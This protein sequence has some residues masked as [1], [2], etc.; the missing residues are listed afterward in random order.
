MNL[1]YN[2]SAGTGKTYQVTGL[3]EKLVL[4]EGIDPREI[5][6]MTFTDNAAA[7]LRMRVSHR[8]MKA[9]RDGEA[10]G[11]FELAE[12][13]TSA[14][15]RLPSAPIGTIHSFCTR[16]LREHALEAGL[17][18]GFSVLI[19]DERDELLNRICR[20]E[21]LKQLDSDPD[22][23]TFCG[24]TQVIG[25]GKGFGSSVT[26]T[27]PDLI[28]QAGSLGISLE[29]AAG[30]LPEPKPAATIQDFSAIL[31]RLREL[32]KRTA[33]AQRVLDALEALLPECGNI[34]AL[35]ERLNAAGLKKF[36]R[37][38]GQKPISDDFSERL[39]AADVAIKYKQRY[40]A[41]LAF[42]RYIQT[43]ATR[44][45]QRKHEMDAVDF[46]D[47][48]HM[49]A[50]LLQTGKAKP[51]FKYVIVDEVQDTSRIQCDLIKAL[52]S[53]DTNLVIC[54]DKKQ[55]IYTWRGADP[56]V[57]PDLEAAIL[58]TE[59]GVCENLQTS[60]RSKA[61]ILDVVN[62]LF[63]AV[64][65]N[66]DYADGDRLL[67]NPDFETEGEKACVEF[68]E[69]DGCAELSKR[70]KVE[71]EMAA[72]ANRIHL[73]VNG[74]PDWKPAYRHSDGFEPT[75]N[76][77]EYR[78]SDILIL[79]RRTTHQ[80]VLEQ[81]LRHAGVPYTLGGKGRGLFT[82]QETR[83]VSLFLNV[84]TNPMDAYSLIGF[85]RS[86][87]VGLSDETL[88][89]LAWNGDDFSI[90]HLMAQ[91]APESTAGTQRLT[92]V[93]RSVPAA[94]AVVRRYRER[95]GDK[96]A[97][98]LVRMLIE[99]TGYDAL[100]AGLPRGT[101]R[102]ANLRKVL[103]WL[104]E[105]ERG[106]QT[107]PAAVARKLAQQIA[108]PPPVPEA[109]LLDPAQNAVTLMTVHGSKGLTKR[110]VMVPDI[111]SSPNADRG[112][113]RVFF[114]ADHHPR[115]GV[116]V[117]A[118]DKNQA[119]SPGFAEANERAKE[120]RAHEL[121]N[122]FYVAMTR[123]RDLVVVSATKGKTAAGW[124]KQLEP[125]IGTR[126]PAIP[127][128]ALADAVERPEQAPAPIPTAEQLAV[129]LESLAPAPA[130]PTLKRIPATR[131]AKEMDELEPDETQ[132]P[133]SF[134]SMDN[135]AALGSLGHAV[136]EQ[137]A[138]NHWTG[139]VDDW[140]EILRDGFGASKTEAA[141]MAP[142]IEQTRAL[143]TGLT[144]LVK[145]L[146]PEFPFVLLEG[147]TLID[148]TIDLLCGTPDGFAIFDYKFTEADDATVAAQYRAQMEIYR[149]AAEKKF[150]RAESADI[151]LVVVS[152]SGARSI[153]I[154]F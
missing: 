66:E 72:V 120:V 24:G 65:G 83:D 77:N 144:G 82:R 111:S 147:D 31:T 6:L 114:D 58:A 73:L 3:Y 41:A 11:D 109:A 105:S 130:K 50:E 122:L 86:P 18:P 94:R 100:L 143:M 103:D 95:L 10:G 52:W 49:A 75:G 76:G 84:V 7:E 57:M 101:Q 91:F 45:R 5:L 131:L 64:Y 69:D 106:A 28:G 27:A 30:I 78:Y 152:T 104:R 74:T 136:L 8:L 51:D 108:N 87:W 148:G 125:L 96:L 60:Y 128:S 14:M 46:D 39:E 55:S 129:A 40:P 142:R 85:L 127:Y 43:V 139:S 110:V 2:A 1:V 68:L 19:G 112:F 16:L 118:P 151:Q 70:E 149:K 93:N 126:I 21:L 63:S 117:S 71:A 145:E 48:L 97:S 32:P 13:A 42:A 34:E 121:N 56:Q 26:E 113:A 79:L 23:R 154:V 92:I 119:A 141:K 98:E 137:L 61:P 29:N 37:G 17:S 132:E 124:L 153:P 89:E 90:D 140:L 35:V 62:A 47:Q 115:L 15:A 107:T 20:E 53:G 134:K 22:F 44:F 99:E 146:H 80:S 81:A 116:K 38:K 67:A 36:G 33:D 135:A 54:G 12:R 133:T 4:E 123:A 9:R 59:N 150:P 88:A 25:S 102:L 138:L